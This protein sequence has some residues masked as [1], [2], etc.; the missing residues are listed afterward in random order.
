M[1]LHS[2]PP[3]VDNNS[4]ILILGSMPGKKSLEMQEYYAHKQNSFWRILYSMFETD[5]SECYKEKIRLLKIQGIALWDTLNACEREGSSD[6]S[7]IKE[8]PND[9]KSFFLS[10]PKIRHV[11]FNGKGANHF[12][13]KHFKPDNRLKYLT[14]PSTSPAHARLSFA[15]KLKQWS[16]IKEILK[17]QNE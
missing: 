5:Y 7:I 15:E 12:F 17:E 8:I 3:I 10:Y 11:F 4:G 2:F 14:L 6:A 9:F 1:L 16:V 13:C